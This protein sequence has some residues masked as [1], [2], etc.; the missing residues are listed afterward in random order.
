MPQPWVDSRRVT[1][2]CLPLL[3]TL[4]VSPAPWL[5]TRFPRSPALGA[6][7]TGTGA[8]THLVLVPLRSI[9]TLTASGA[10]TFLHSTSNRIPQPRPCPLV[11]VAHTSLPVP[12]TSNASPAEL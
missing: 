10:G 7:M 1:Q 2:T 5:L 8:F 9:N 6:H 12:T 3:T 4:K 11:R